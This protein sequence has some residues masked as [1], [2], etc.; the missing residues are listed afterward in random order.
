[1][2]AAVSKNFSLGLIFQGSQHY[3]PKDEE[4]LYFGNNQGFINGI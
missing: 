2:E 4:I 3:V 1:M